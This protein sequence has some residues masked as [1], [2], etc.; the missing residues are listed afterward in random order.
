MV[1][2]NGEQPAEKQALGGRTQWALGGSGVLDREPGW[3]SGHVHF[4]NFITLFTISVL[5]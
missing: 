3:L 2:R 5:F 4:V 1:L